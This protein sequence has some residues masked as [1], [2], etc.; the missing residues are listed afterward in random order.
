MLSQRN[1]WD[2]LRSVVVG[3]SWPPEF[4]AWIQDSA[5]RGHMERIAQETEEDLS[6]LVRCFESLGVEVMRPEI[7]T[8]IDNL[9]EHVLTTR[10]P[11]DPGD[12]LLMAGSTLVTSFQPG[13]QD[14]RHYD[15][16]IDHVR[17]QGN[18][19]MTTD[20]DSLC[21]AGVYQLGQQVFYTVSEAERD[22]NLEMI[23][24]LSQLTAVPQV[25]RMHQ[26]G[27]IDAWFTPVTPG[28]IIAWDDPDRP[29]LLQMFFQR[30]F[31]GWEIVRLAPT[32]IDVN[33]FQ[34]WRQQHHGRWWLP[35][36]EDNQS[37]INF[38]DTYCAQ[39]LGDVSETAF[40]LNMSI[41]DERNCIVSH[42]NQQVF[43]A[44]QRHGVTPHITPL[45]Y[46]NFW[47]GAVHCVTTELHRQG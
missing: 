31:P 26:H 32:L 9:Q 42:Y 24:T 6:G 4:Y 47:D 13:G 27:H 22:R 40:D 45:R 20:L 29:E 8:Q 43:E 3:R 39:W 12:D 7:V 5:V 14:A 37:L 11:M 1:M 15:N 36:Q 2:R 10:P 28:L 17:S 16:I 44:L 25:H 19:V 38:I 35:G 30:Y 33:L 41:V 18:L 23:Q 21:G 34:R 46:A